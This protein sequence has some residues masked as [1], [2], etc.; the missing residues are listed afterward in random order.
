MKYHV[1]ISVI[2]THIFKCLYTTQYLNIYETCMSKWLFQ[3]IPDITL[4]PAAFLVQIVF[5]GV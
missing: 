2:F 3:A 1:Y 4:P 5:G